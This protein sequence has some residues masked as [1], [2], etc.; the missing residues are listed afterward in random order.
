M[1]SVLPRS[2]PPANFFFSHL[3]AFIAASAA[4]RWRASASS[5]PIASSATLMLLAPGAFMT[6]MPRALAASRSTLSTP[7]PARAITRS[8]GAAA[9]TSRVTLVALRTTSAS[10]SA[11]AA[12]SSGSGRPGVASTIQPCL[13]GEQGNSGPR[14]IIGN[15]NFHRDALENVARERRSGRPRR[16]TKRFKYNLTFGP[17]RQEPTRRRRAL[18]QHGAN[19]SDVPQCRGTGPHAPTFPQTFPQASVNI[20]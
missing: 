13:L 12:S 14:Q 8:L 20:R 4:G 7:V 18:P 3:C 6:M 10:A 19:R 16:V 5:W 2:S 17:G 15:H 9:M 1:P 11:T